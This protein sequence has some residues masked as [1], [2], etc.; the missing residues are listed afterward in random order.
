M[1]IKQVKHWM[2]LRAS[3]AQW[4]PIIDWAHSRK[5]ELQVVDEGEGFVID[6]ERHALGPLRIEWGAPQRDY[7]QWPE[8]RLR[9]EVKLSGELQMMVIERHLLEV[10]ERAVFEAYT[11][12]LQT[13]ADADTPEEMRWLVMFSKADQWTSKVARS[14]FSACAVTPEVAS[15]WVAAGLGE[16]LAVA[17]QDLVP[18]EHPFVMLTQ[19]GNVYL[20]TAMAVPALESIKGFVKLA[21]T[22]ALE[23]Q[24]VQLKLG[25]LGA[26]P[27]TSSM[28][29]A[30]SSGLATD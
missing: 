8:L 22:A 17:S 1:V 27:N 14:R 21:E 9:L 12:T 16:A 28:T 11:D 18:A 26:W 7:M 5:G 15:Q 10:L 20:R 4:K 19:R 25:D 29:W 24:Q 3:A 2:K 13:R 23:A 6:E 30:P